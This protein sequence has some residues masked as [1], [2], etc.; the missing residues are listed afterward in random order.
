M[1]ERE[2]RVGVVGVGSLGTVLCEQFADVPGARVAAVADVSD[3]NRATAGD[4]FG[5][6]EGARYADHEAMF[7]GADLDAAV[8]TTPHALHHEHVTA[9]MDR[10]LHVLCEKPL[11]TSLADARDL[12]E[13]DGAREEVLMVGYQRHL[14]PAFLRARERWAAGDRSPNF[15][16]AEITQDLFDALAGEWYLDP[17]LS[18]GG[19]IYSTGTHLIDAVLWT[20]G[21]D[22]AA[23]TASLNLHEGRER[24]DKHAAVTVEFDGGAVATLGISGDTPRTYEHFHGWEDDGA[25]YVDGRQ[26]DP[27]TVRVVDAEGT[28]HEPHLGEARSKAAAFVEAAREGLEPPATARDALRATA[29]QEAIY[30][31]DDRGERVAV[32][33]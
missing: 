24:L 14:D 33:L 12:V 1:T 19:Q 5:V 3:E 20:T 2:F 15:L 11:V 22:P 8:V 25:V 9:A 7:D 32:D 13:R 18:G 29:V 23:V 26:W 30:E 6:P 10:D 27:R 17:D 16:T 4:R 21:L 31:A 28:E